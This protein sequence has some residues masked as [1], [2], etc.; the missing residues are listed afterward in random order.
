MFKTQK[1]FE[2]TITVVNEGSPS[3]ASG[4]IAIISDGTSKN[5]KAVIMPDIDTHRETRKE[6]QFEV[7]VVFAQVRKSEMDKIDMI[8][9]KTRITWNGYSYRVT[10][11]VDYRSKPLFKNAE[12]EMRRRIGID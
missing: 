9:G 8:P 10:S 6:G 2:E 11:I 1:Q 5:I 3:Y 12:I 4:G 7:E